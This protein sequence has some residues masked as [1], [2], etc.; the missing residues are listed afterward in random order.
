MLVGIMR[1]SAWSCERLGSGQRRAVEHG[2]DVPWQRGRKG[3]GC[4]LEA[5]APGGASVG[6][7]EHPDNRY[8]CWESLRKWAV[9]GGRVWSATALR[10]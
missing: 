6:G 5:S 8:H 4:R 10:R 7:S 2:A 3:R 9:R 1:G